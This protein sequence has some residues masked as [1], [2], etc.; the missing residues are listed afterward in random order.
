VTLI[1]DGTILYSNPHF[2]KMVQREAEQVIGARFQDLILPAKREAFEAMLK[3]TGPD[4][5]R[6]EF[7]IQTTDGDCVQVLLSAYELEMDGARGISIIATDLTERRQAEDALRKSEALFRL[8]ATN[9]PDVI[10]SQDLN[11]EYTWII[12]PAT[13][14]TSGQ[15]VGKTDWDL[16]PPNEA[17][18]LTELK[19][20]I[21]A[22]GASQ[23]RELLFSIDGVP[24]WFDNIYQP[25]YDRNGQIT[26]LLGYSRNITESVLAKEKIRSLASA[27]TK[28]EQE[29]RHRISQI[30]HDDLQQRLFAVK[31]Q[32]SMLTEG[33]LDGLPLQV[34]SELEQIQ[35]SLSDTISITRNL[36]IS[37]SP[38][39]L[40][41]EGLVDA[42]LW[43]ASQMREQ[44]DLQVEIDAKVNLNRLEEHIRVLLFRAVRELLFNIVKHAG[45][46]QAAV[47]LEQV[48]GRVCITVTDE[49]AGFDAEKVLNDLALAHGLLILRDR[50]NLMGGTMEVD[51]KVG[52]GTRVRIEMPVEI[53]PA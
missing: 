44:F 27:L 47:H 16:L 38:A 23:R 43:L 2:C 40:R 28:A 24:H 14:F 10:F 53:I 8:I 32:L 45:T 34:H 11:L 7:C 35:R 26:G 29:E 46:R 9:S 1:P 41:G 15:V 49:G 51:S 31:A 20:G 50:L 17:E 6:A 22:T 25:T 18:Q 33:N 36:S 48:D 12:N 19:K 37:L 5:V 52:K 13:P 42:I 4:G 21:L 39:I 30:L 3:E